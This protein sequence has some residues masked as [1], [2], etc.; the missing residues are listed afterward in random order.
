M[1]VWTTLV[2]FCK[3]N[4]VLT[5]IWEGHTLIRLGWNW[6]H[7]QS[8][9]NDLV[10]K[11]V[12][13]FKNLATVVVLIDTEREHD[14]A[15]GHLWNISHN[16]TAKCIHLRSVRIFNENL[17]LVSLWITINNACLHFFPSKSDTSSTS[18]TLFLGAVVS[19][20]CDILD[21]SDGHTCTCKCSNGC[22]CAWTCVVGLVATRCTVLDD[23]L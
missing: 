21:S 8:V 19:D 12:D 22:L 11:C 10:W 3:I 9:R 18:S 4:T 1:T 2:L 6:N 17:D 7:G 16:R 15:N 20:W 5:L 14:L 23:Q 13:R